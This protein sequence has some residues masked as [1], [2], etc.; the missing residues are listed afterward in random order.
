[1]LQNPILSHFDSS[2]VNRFSPILPWPGDPQACPPLT[3]S[4]YGP[5]TTRRQGVAKSHRLENCR[6]MAANRTPDLNFNVDFYGL[7][8]TFSATETK[9]PSFR[10]SEMLVAITQ[11]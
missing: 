3:T 10:S 2:R 9:K 6:L 4:S 1:M 7:K 8:V 11:H 5:I